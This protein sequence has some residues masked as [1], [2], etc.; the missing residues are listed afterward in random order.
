[1]QVNTRRTQWETKRVFFATPQVIYND[2]KSGICPGKEIRCLVIDEAHKARGNYAYC[3]IIT[4]LNEVGHSCYRVLALSATPGSKVDDVITVSCIFILISFTLFPALSRLG[5]KNLVLRP[6]FP[7]FRW[8]FYMSSLI[9]C[10]F[11][12]R[13]LEI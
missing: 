12:F 11:C 5:R 13:L 10:S 3:Q 2:I 8:R 7:T 4:T 9:F 6:V 1:M